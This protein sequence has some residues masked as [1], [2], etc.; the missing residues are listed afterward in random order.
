MGEKLRP[1][2]GSSFVI[3]AAFLAEL[4]IER[5][6]GEMVKS[7][8]DQK[9]GFTITWADGWIYFC[10]SVVVTVTSFIKDLNYCS[11][12]PSFSVMSY[13]EGVA[14]KE[15]EPKSEFEMLFDPPTV[16]VRL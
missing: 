5:K 11:R 9:E 13:V 1:Y 8:A 6:I 10:K 4:D 16:P 7:V 3:A 15:S 14:N 2:C 12:I